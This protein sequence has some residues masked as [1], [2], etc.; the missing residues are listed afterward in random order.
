VR[1]LQAN[2]LFER[3]PVSHRICR[4]YTH[5]AE[6]SAALTAALDSLIGGSAQDDLTNM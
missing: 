1:P 6:H 2:Q 5:S 4:V 3:L